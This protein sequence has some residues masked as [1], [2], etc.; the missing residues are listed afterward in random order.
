MTLGTHVAFASVLYLGGATLF[1]YRP[2]YPKGVVRIEPQLPSTW[3]HASIATPDFSLAIRGGRYDLALTRPAAVE[4]RVPVRARKVDAVTVNGAPVRWT[5]EPGYGSSVVVVKM[6][7]VTTA[8]VEVAVSRPLTN[9][10]ARALSIQHGQSLN[11]DLAGTEPLSPSHLPTSAGHHVLEYLVRTGDLPQTRLFK[12]HIADA[13]ADA[14]HAAKRLTNAPAGAR[15]AAVDMAAQLNG[16]VR[17]IFKQEYLSPRPPTCSLRLAKDGYSTWQMMLKKTHRAP[18]VDLKLMDGL[19]AADGRIRI[20]AGAEFAWPAGGSNIAFTSLWDNWPDA[21]TVPV[22][23]GGEALWFLVTGF[24]PPMQTGI[25]NAELRLTYA[26][27]VVEKL[28]LV[29]PQ[30]FWSLCPFGGSDYDYSRDAFALPKEPP[31]QV[32]LG[33]NCR[34]MVYG[35]KLRPG[36]AVQSVTLETLSPEVI[37]GLMAA[38]VMNPP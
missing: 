2:D 33:G 16:D 25:A 13:D 30:N 29:P 19:R 1:G 7:A 4:L 35:W 27:G 8:R 24:T 28:E 17:E 26:D 12:I 31:T 21:V 9:A 15:W 23:R 22:N 37:V 11:I 14:A 3:D 18:E 10:P 38:S 36:V 20:P 34:A 5:V 6:P 32:Q